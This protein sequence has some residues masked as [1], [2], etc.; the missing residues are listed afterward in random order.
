MKYQRLSLVVAGIVVS[1]AFAAQP[2]PVWAALCAKCRDLMFTESQGKCIDC[3]G[4]TG[5]GALQLCPACSA[6]RHQCEHCL[7]KLTAAEERAVEA[8]PEEKDSPATAGVHSATPPWNAPANVVLG[9][10]VAGAW[11]ICEPLALT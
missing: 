11:R 5:S 6:K 4:P 9:L 10:R 7:A 2:S 1:A 3:G 8:K